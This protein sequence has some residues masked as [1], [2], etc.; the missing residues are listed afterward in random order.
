MC[1]D[2]PGRS[3]DGYSSA[4]IF[5]SAPLQIN[6]DEFLDVT[7]GGSVLAR[8]KGA[9]VGRTKLLYEPRMQQQTC[10]H[11]SPCKRTYLHRALYKDGCV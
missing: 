4:V 6:I 3:V 8:R 10:S 5:A 1:I 7:G 9:Y 11:M 2:L